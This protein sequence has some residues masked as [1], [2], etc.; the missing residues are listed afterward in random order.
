MRHLDHDYVTELIQRIERIPPDAKPAWGSMTP[1][2]LVRHLLATV[3]YSMGHTGKGEVTGPWYFRAVVGPL[4]F[5]GIIPIPRNVPL[6][7]RTIKAQQAQEHADV[8]T[9]HA[10]LEEYLNLVQAGELSPEPHPYF[11]HIGVDGWDKMHVR[12][13]EH[14]LKQFGA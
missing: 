7:E 12:H 6:P 5:N 2:A 10:V 8:E 11:G 4:I 13:F 1:D 14:H 3:K 9:L